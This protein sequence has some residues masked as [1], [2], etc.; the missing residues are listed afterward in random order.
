MLH[1]QIMIIHFAQHLIENIFLF[2]KVTSIQ[3]ILYDRFE[4]NNI[5]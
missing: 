1:K 2:I 4:T 3:F 5:D